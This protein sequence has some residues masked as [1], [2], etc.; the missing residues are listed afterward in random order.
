MK[1][2][3]KVIVYT[4]AELAARGWYEDTGRIT[5][6]SGMRLDNHTVFI[7]NDMIDNCGG[8]VA[9]ITSVRDWP[10]PDTCTLDID[11]QK[12]SWTDKM[13]TPYIARTRN[14]PDWW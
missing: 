7:N 5:G 12:W 13:F 2:G 10:I 4:R 6:R 1:V 14:L 3:D 9:I 11:L 8:K